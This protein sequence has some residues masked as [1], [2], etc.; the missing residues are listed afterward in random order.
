MR[1]PGKE[2]PTASYLSSYLEL[3]AALISYAEVNLRRRKRW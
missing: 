1:G 3:N 2:T